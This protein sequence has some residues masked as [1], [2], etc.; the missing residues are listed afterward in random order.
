MTMRRELTR[1]TLSARLKLRSRE[2]VV[3]LALT[4]AAAAML[5]GALSAPLDV[6]E[7]P[8]GPVASVPV[9]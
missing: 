8:S 2:V 4:L 6:S 3:A 9:R 7:R 1:L 5:I